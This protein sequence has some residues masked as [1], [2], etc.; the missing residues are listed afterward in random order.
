[1]AR[2]V[3]K[4]G[5]TSVASVA[6][7]KRVASKVAAE[8]NKNQQIVVVVSAMSGVTNDLISLCRQASPFHDTREYDAIV[9]T[10]EQISASLL[11]IALQE[12]EIPARSWA[13]WQLP[14]YTDDIHGNARIQ[15]IE[16]KEIEERLAENEIVVVTGFQ[17]LSK[18]KRIT[19]FGRGGS[20]ITAVALAAALKADR[21]D[22]YTDVDGIYTADPNIVPQAKK[23][24]QIS[25][26]E[27]LAFAEMGAKV[28]QPRSVDLAL[29]HAVPLQV[30]ST[31]TSKI[32]SDYPG[33]M[34]E[35]AAKDA[36]PHIAGITHQPDLF[37]LNV[38]Y[39]QESRDEIWSLFAK[40]K[41]AFLQPFSLAEGFDEKYNLNRLHLC[42]EAPQY[43]RVEKMAK[44]LLKKPITWELQKGFHK[45]SVIGNHLNNQ[46]KIITKFHD[47]LSKR[48]IKVHQYL[49][50][51]TKLSAL[52]EE[53][54]TELAVRSLHQAFELDKTE[55]DYN[56]TQ[57]KKAQKRG[58]KTA[59]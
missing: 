37:V 2:I 30:L 15:K 18:R 11:A 53:D 3:L 42:F 20:D 22:I 40:L 31:F 32:G 45:I 24:A 6:Q 21:C 35:K 34:L 25:H 44:S 49:F 26:K 36:K 57:K 41:K 47:I 29:K 19:T 4:F 52:I 56:V 12:L 9:S 50:S 7:I 23:L 5:G 33:T 8:Y 51:D 55:Q 59:S 43:E 58:P 27:M 48:K 28:L 54:F 39:A 13:A 38:T 16:T 1:M 14:I 10:G 46:P 17:G